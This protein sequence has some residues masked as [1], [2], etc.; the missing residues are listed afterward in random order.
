MKQHTLT[1]LPGR[2]VIVCRDGEF[3]APALASAGIFLRTDC[4]GKGVC[5]K[6]RVTL[7]E[8]STDRVS[9][10]GGD[11]KEL[12][13]LAC[14]TKVHG[15]IELTIPAATLMTATAVTK[16]P[17][18]L[19]SGY[20]PAGEDFRE[21]DLG[22]AVD[23]G[24]T[25]IALYLVSLSSKK[26][27]GSLSV[28]NP[29]TVFGA[30]V[31]A[32][33]DAV[34]RNDEALA[35]QRTLVVRAIEWGCRE[36]LTQA[37]TQAEQ[38]KSIVAV[39]NTT[40]IHI[41]AGVSPAP[42][43]VAPYAPVFTDIRRLAFDD[44]VFTLAP[45]TR[46]TTLPLLSG[47]LGCDI[48]SAALAVDLVNAPPGTLLVDIGTNGEIMLKNHDGIYAASC[49][50]G[51][52]FEGGAL[53]CGMP[54]VE[55]AV[56]RV[57]IDPDTGRAGFTQIG[58]PGT[59][60]TGICGSGIIGAMAELLRTGLVLPD[61][62]FDT[63]RIPGAVGTDAEGLPAYTIAPENK[64]S[65]FP[66]VLITQKDIRALQ[67]AKGA[68]MAGIELLL[69]RAGMDAPTEVLL[70]GAFGSVLRED[71]ALAVGMLPQGSRGKIRFVG[72]AAGTGAV[73][74]LCDRKKFSA[75]EALAA[76]TRVFNLADDPA[77]NELFINA[78]SFP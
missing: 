14:R 36:L 57:T 6:C 44:R 34:R 10:D 5:G 62:R 51:P 17:A 53:S 13:C 43:G 26:L 71:D 50:T 32:R 42:L 59:G 25:T 72:N 3:I 68:L 38:L 63:R 19:P 2:R 16:A 24:T 22:V 41:L 37:G 39:G 58:E 35:T 60:A 29:Q 7:S 47:F 78:L 76:T 21:D 55:G 54:A 67:L 4:G 40:M 52:A 74:A 31:M 33:I 18:L 46:W 77:F 27:L 69:K 9:G 23:L 8:S 49:A 64:A 48:V 1:L 73:L 20:T 56:D 15:D 11:T 70:A 66:P 75:M 45:S 30:D 65:G 28:K 61:G 12:H